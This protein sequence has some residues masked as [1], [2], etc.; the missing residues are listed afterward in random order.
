MEKIV[1]KINFPK[2]WNPFLV[3]ELGKVF[4][5]KGILK[6][7]IQNSGFPCIRYGEIY[8]KYHYNFDKTISYINTDTAQKSREIKFGDILFS[9]SGE[10]A[11]EIGKAV[12]YVG[13]NKAYAGGDIVVLRPNEPNSGLFFGYLMNSDY[14]VQQKFQEGQGHSVV[15]IYGKSVERLKVILPPLPEQQKIAA[16]L[17]KWDELIAEQTQLIAAKGKQKKGLMQQLLSGEVRFPGFDKEWEYKALTDITEYLGGAAF[18]S[19]DQVD[20][21]IKWLK[22][23]NIGIGKLKWDVTAYLP[24]SFVKEFEKYRL[25]VGNVVMALTRP[26]LNN[27]LKIAQIASGSGESL[28]NQRVAKLIPKGDNSLTYIYY[29]H[30][31]QRTVNFINASIAGTD[32]P[33]ISLK[34]LETI[35]IRIPPIIEQHKIASILSSCDEEIQH[36]KDELEAI[37]LQKKGLMQEL[38]TGRLRVP[39]PT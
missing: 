35:S 29:L 9:G 2:D 31:S 12:A 19:K 17:S 7:E 23:A 22:I 11:E 25:V 8:T 27:K 34:E 30:Q 28:L 16:I 21:G 5:G 15:H 26:I 10:T 37:K 4:K 1:D 3:N 14:V 13:G 32:P 33:N 38:L 36:L 18:K 20:S 39:Q 6:S 24:P